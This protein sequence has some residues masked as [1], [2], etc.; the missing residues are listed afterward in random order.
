MKIAFL[1]KYQEYCRSKDSRND[2][3]KMQQQ[4]DETIED[5]VERFVYNLQKSRKNELNTNAIRNVFLKG[6]QEDYIDML[7]LMVAGD[8]SQKPFKEIIEVCRKYSCSK[9][10]AWK[11]IREIKSIGGGVT[12]TE[13]GNLLENFKMDILGILSSQIDSTNIKK[14]FEDEALTI[15]CSRCKKRHPLKICPLNVVSLCGL[16]VEDH[17]TDNFP[18][19]P[20]LQA[21]YKGASEL[22][23]QAT[24]GV[25]KKPWQAR[26]QGMFVDPYS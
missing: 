9:S 13:L 10:K 12:H 15:F 3:F 1:R 5:Y 16:C 7:N 26:P 17:E 22:A 25:Q 4:E 24:Q 6:V 11:G 14:K 19:L 2:I 20:G 23:G 18:S 21:I 8:I